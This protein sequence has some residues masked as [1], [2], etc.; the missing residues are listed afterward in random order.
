MSTEF[1]VAA[2]FE[3]VVQKLVPAFKTLGEGFE[4]VL[5]KMT[6]AGEHLILEWKSSMYSDDLEYILVVTMNRTMGIR[7]G[8]VAIPPEHPVR[9]KNEAGE[10]GGIIEVHGG[11]SFYGNHATLDKL[12]GN[13]SEPH[14][15][16]GF[17][18]GHYRDGHDLDQIDSEELRE[19]YR[20]MDKG[21]S[22]RSLDFMI[23][24][25]EYLAS[26]L[27]EMR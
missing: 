2:K 1:D 5:E 12:L 4:N 9:R 15:W 13:Y 10:L 6:V 26:Q 3:K 27:A 17:D 11:V 16:I 21:L 18:A 8:Y 25:T 20:L 7:C 23:Q 14:F 19:I 22:V 24:E